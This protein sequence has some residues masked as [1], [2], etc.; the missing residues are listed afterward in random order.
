[1][2]GYTRRCPSS[3]RILRAQSDVAISGVGVKG[4][5][6]AS[7]V[8]LRLGG[9]GQTTHAPPSVVLGFMRLQDTLTTTQ[10]IHLFCLLSSLISSHQ[11]GR[12]R[13]D[14]GRR[15]IYR[16]GTPDLRMA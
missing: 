4:G 9:G 2:K 5:Y 6:E 7:K 15:D 16:V 3:T 14:E 10:Y 12:G 1:M 8:M 13:K 11:P